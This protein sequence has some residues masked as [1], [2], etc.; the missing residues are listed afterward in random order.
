MEELA[1]AFRLAFAAYRIHAGKGDPYKAGIGGNIAGQPLGAH[2]AAVTG[3]FHPGRKG[4][5]RLAGR[6]PAVTVQY[7]HL[8]G[9]RGIIGQYADGIIVDMQAVRH[10]FQHNGTGLIRDKPVQGGGRQLTA[11]R[12]IGQVHGFQRGARFPQIGTAGKQPRDKLELGDVFFVLTGLGI[13]GIAHKVQPC[14]AES[15]FI[16]GIV[17]KRIAFCH[18]CHADYSIMLGQHCTMP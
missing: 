17:I 9:E 5:F 15:F 1:D 13:G 7:C 16:D 4:V 2:A 12:G 3:Q 8:L 6:K 11:E 18:I 14:H 10:A